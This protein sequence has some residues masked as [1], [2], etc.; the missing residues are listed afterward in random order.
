MIT[1]L[2][3]P[4]SFLLA[5][6]MQIAAAVPVFSGDLISENFDSVR[7]GRVVNSTRLA[8]G[9][10]KGY[11]GSSAGELGF[12]EITDDKSAEGKGMALCFHDNW[13][14]KERGGPV[15]TVNWKES[16]PAKGHLIVEWSWMVPVEGDFLAVQFLG[17]T[18]EDAAAILSAQN[19]AIILQYDTQ[20]RDRLAS[21][22]PGQWVKVKFDFDIASKTF[23]FYLNDK[24]SINTYKWQAGSRATVDTL[25]M[26]ADGAPIDRHGDAVFYVDDILVKSDN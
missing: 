7:L 3:H 1:N 25:K 26:I 4:R 18:W 14:E 8:D 23:S 19:G 12:F 9:Q 22:E 6:A 10:I 17:G 20:T 13:P 21:Y 24:K 15:L 11:E 16:S 2:I 5:A